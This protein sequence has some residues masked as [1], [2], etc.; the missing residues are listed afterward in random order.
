[1]LNEINFEQ[2]RVILN[3]I[4][5]LI[6]Q[7]LDYTFGKSGHLNINYK[8]DQTIVTDI[9]IFV[10][11]LFKEKFQSKFPFLNF[12][13]E[14]EQNSLE[15]P[16]LI[17]DP[18]D[19]T[20]ELAKGVNECCVSFGI[21]F[22]AHIEDQRNFSWIY[23]PFT[24]FEIS[25]ETKFLKNHRIINE[26]LMAYVSR[27]EYE[28]GIYQSTQKINFYPKGSIAYK[29]ALLAAGAG[30]FVI[31]KKPK[32]IWDIL[33]GTH[34]CN[35]RGISLFNNKKKVMTLDSVLIANDLLWACEDV[36]ETIKEQI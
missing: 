25:S 4:K 18:I 15:Y 23:N 30:D 26:K 32:N 24:N 8:P 34:I 7:K 3:E 33:A 10:S 27:T 13:S 21:Y 2:I 12:F 9:D 36:W 5:G 31:S 19:G 29:L 28:K 11:K 35:S 1:M 6:G 22:S 14:E 20:K 17:L 16:V